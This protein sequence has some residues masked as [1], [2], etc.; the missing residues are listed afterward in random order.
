MQRLQTSQLPSTKRS[1]GGSVRGWYLL[2]EGNDFRWPAPEH[3]QTVVRH[4]PD[5]Q[6]NSQTSRVDPETRTGALRAEV[7]FVG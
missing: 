1:Q 3:I 4:L 2:Y 7:E 6:V 5:R